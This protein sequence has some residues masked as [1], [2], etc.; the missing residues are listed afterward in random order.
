MCALRTLA[1]THLNCL[2][3]DRICTPGEVE[4][5][6]SE[7]VPARKEERG[8][9]VMAW[10]ECMVTVQSWPPDTHIRTYVHTVHYRYVQEGETCH[11]PATTPPT[12][13]TLGKPLPL[14]K[15]AVSCRNIW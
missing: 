14:K 2:A 9:E 12:E 13:Q 6:W 11:P 1:H 15:A 3:S 8:A 5:L 4:E 7:Q 10:L